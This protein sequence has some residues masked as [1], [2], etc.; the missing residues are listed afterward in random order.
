[1]SEKKLDSFARCCLSRL[2]AEVYFP[3]MELKCGT[4]L[5]HHCISSP[6]DFRLRSILALKPRLVTVMSTR[7]RLAT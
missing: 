7:N 4:S 6:I 3:L 5:N 1:M 2:S